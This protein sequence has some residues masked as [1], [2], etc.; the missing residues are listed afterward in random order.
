MQCGFK[1]GQWLVWGL[2]LLLTVPPRAIACEMVGGFTLCEPQ[3]N[4]LFSTRGLKDDALV[5]FNQLDTSPAQRFVTTSLKLS[6]RGD[7]EWG[8]GFVM[9]KRGVI[10]TP[11]QATDNLNTTLT[12]HLDRNTLNAFTLG[13]EMVEADSYY[14]LSI[15]RQ[16]TL[17][18]NQARTILYEQNQTATVSASMIERWAN[19]FVLSLQLDI[20]VLLRG[21]TYKS[22]LMR[23]LQKDMMIG[24]EVTLYRDHVFQ[25][26]RLGVALGGIRMFGSDY[27][28]ALGHES[29]SLS[30]A[31]LY[32]SLMA[33]RRF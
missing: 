10:F 4:A 15:G 20:D 5:V 11:H 3:G 21:A 30:H 31:G 2:V 26:Q 22:S 8:G 23:P 33:A 28:L 18:T 32:T 16:W 27:S 13:W 7:E 24:P 19:G 12:S 1:S 17:R 25:R 9:A 14:A 29:D 6:M